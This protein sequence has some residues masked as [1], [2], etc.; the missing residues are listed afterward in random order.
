MSTE[1]STRTQG[2]LPAAVEALLATGDLGKLTIEQRIEFYKA[3]CAAANLDPRGRP[4]EY[5]MLQGKL[6]LYAKKECAEQLNGIHGLSH[7]IIS[8]EIVSGLYEVCVRVTSSS[9]R[10]SED[11]GT[12]VIEGLKGADLA[13]ARMKAVTKAKRRATLSF[14]GLG[15]VID[16]TELDTVEYSPTGPQGQALRFANNSGHATGMYASPAETESFLTAM[17]A[18][19]DKR[20]AAW[21]ERWQDR[22]TG[23]FPAGLK[24]DLI[25]E[26]QADNHLVK[27]AVETGRLDSA[28]KGESV[29]ARNRGRFTAI[30]YHRS[31]AER[32]A[33]SQELARYCDEQERLQTERLRRID[34]ELFE[35]EPGSDD[36]LTEDEAMDR[37]TRE[38]SN[39]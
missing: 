9:G 28:I 34:P 24:K 17:R 37:I 18:Y 39:D 13:N 35:R 12:V 38:Q 16:E 14:C 7:E 20:N 31:T 3:R 25:N 26:H 8:R 15:D 19:L 1:L 30:I 32:R 2:A 5:I 27:W 6:T 4:F 23:E 11:I 33:I 21:L 22:Q 10:T 29:Q 36:V